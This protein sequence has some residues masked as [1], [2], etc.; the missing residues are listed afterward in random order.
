MDAETERGVGRCGVR[1]EVGGDV[2]VEV[3]FYMHSGL[4]QYRISSTLNLKIRYSGTMK[5]TWMRWKRTILD[6]PVRHPAPLILQ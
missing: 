4:S 6:I 5:E 1:E 3:V 2:M